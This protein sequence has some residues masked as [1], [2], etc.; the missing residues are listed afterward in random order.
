MIL[1]GHRFI[2]SESFY[3]I[4]DV[5]SVKKT[6]SNSLI[7]LDFNEENL[8]I[9][10]HLTCN[11]ITFALYVHSIKEVVYAEN[12]GASYIVLDQTLAKDAQKIANE[13][14]FDSKILAHID[15][16]DEIENLAYQGIDGAIFLKAIIKISS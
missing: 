13:Y 14:L 8:D 9:I 3:H 7:Y 11:E 4:D 5:S 16:E 6:P 10:E 12:L 1:F 15:N 2:E